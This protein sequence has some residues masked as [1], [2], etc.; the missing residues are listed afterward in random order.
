MTNSQRLSLVR[1]ALR[2]WISQHQPDAID[3]QQPASE[4]ML[5][6]DG[7]F[8]G[9]RFRLGDYQA[10][11]FIE[12]DELKIRD[13][14]G[15]ALVLLNAAQIDDLARAWDV[16]LIAD[17]ANQDSLQSQDHAASRYSAAAQDDAAAQDEVQ[18][19]SIKTHLESL[20]NAANDTQHRRAA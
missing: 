15:T 1:N 3:L 7:F 5:I 20:E 13:Q 2:Q 8:C 10:V 12:E 16:R 9:R 6:R 19:L 4:A 17:A 18:T 11:W 14:H